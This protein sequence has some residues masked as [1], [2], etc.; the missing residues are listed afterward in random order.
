MSWNFTPEY[1]KDPASLN[2]YLR[3]ECCGSGKSEETQMISGLANAYQALFNIITQM[4]GVSE[5]D[6]VLL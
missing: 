1:L 5:I 4:E 3:E 2:R 6:R